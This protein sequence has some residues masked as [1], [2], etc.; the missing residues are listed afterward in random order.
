MGVVSAV[1]GYEGTIYFL[2]LYF[3][4]WRTVNH[5]LYCYAWQISMRLTKVGGGS[6]FGGRDVV[7]LNAPGEHQETYNEVISASMKLSTESCVKFRLRR[8][9]TRY[10]RF[11]RRKPEDSPRD[12]GNGD[13]TCD[14]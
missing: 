8:G 5:L 2:K 7:T 4:G 6:K 12:Q 13:L 9:A 10:G 1:K 14:V 3:A 11:H